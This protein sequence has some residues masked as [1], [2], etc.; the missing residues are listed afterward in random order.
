MTDRT[1]RWLRAMLM[2][3]VVGTW[4][5][6]GKGVQAQG[7]GVTS[8]VLARGQAD[9]AEVIGGPAEVIVAVV[10]LEPGASIGW[11][12]HAGP[13]TGVVTRGE[14]TWYGADGCPTVYP[15]GA[16]AFVAPDQVHDERNE[17]TEPLELVVTYVVPAGSP[18]RLEATAPAAPCPR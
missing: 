15:A 8:E 4:L 12:R 5:V 18:L 7:P 10:T 9:Y 17:G 14:L 3:G 11:H 2:L 6:T 13:V 1:R 16:A